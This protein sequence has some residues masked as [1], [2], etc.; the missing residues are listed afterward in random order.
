MENEV[1]KDIKDYEGLYQV[2]NLGRIKSF[3]RNGTIKQTREKKQK[4]D[5]YGYKCVDLY[6]N[7]KLKTCKVHRL[8]AEAFLSNPNNYKII[9]H[10]NKKRDDNVIDNLE[11]CTVT[12][13]VRYSK[14]KRVTQYDL[15]GK[16]IKTWNCIR[17]AGKVLKICNGDIVK[18]CK[19]KKRTAGGYI[20]KYIE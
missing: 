20:W 1:W 4:Y 9:N 6:K 7:N 13:N 18:C 16:F 2:S 3:P 17:E 19:N 11:W 8:V 15:N 5:K 10:L 12:H 14:A